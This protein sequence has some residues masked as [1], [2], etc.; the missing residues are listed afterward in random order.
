LNR[1]VIYGILIF[2]TLS[3]VFGGSSSSGGNAYAQSTTSTPKMFVLGSE[4]KSGA[5]EI[6][7]RAVQQGA[8]IR[9]IKTFDIT[10][11]NVVQAKQGGSIK[12]FSSDQSLKIVKAKVRTDTAIENLIELPRTQGNTF[13]LTGLV[14]G[15]Y[16]LDIIAQK[17]NRDL[18]YETILVILDP[19]ETTITANL[20]IINNIIT[21]VKTEVNKTEKNIIKIIRGN[22]GGNDGDGDPTPQPIFAPDDSC[23]LDPFQEK[24][25]PPEGQS[26]P[27]GFGSNE[28][29]HCIPDS[30]CPQGYH[31]VDDVE[32]GQCHPKSELTECTGGGHVLK[33]DDCVYGEPLDTLPICDGSTQRCRVALPTG[34]WHI[35]EI[36]TT[37][38]EC[39]IEDPEVEP[40]ALQP[41]SAVTTPA[42]PCLN[43]E[44]EQD[45]KQCTTGMDVGSIACSQGKTVDQVCAENPETNGCGNE[46][47]PEPITLEPEQCIPGTG[48]EDE[49]C[50]SEIPDTVQE[51]IPQPEPIPE[52]SAFGPDLDPEEPGIQQLD[53]EPG[54]TFTPA[55]PELIPDD[56][57]GDQ[58]QEII[59]DDSSDGD[60]D[61]NGN[62]DNGL[63]SEDGD[64]SNGGSAEEDS[65]SDNGGD[66]Q[67]STES[68]GEEEEGGGGGGESEGSADEEG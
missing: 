68:G 20:Q 34:N 9:Q 36:G 43:D 18:A 65:D 13:S 7:L 58:D 17:N 27:E 49:A 42:G 3:L 37:D 31:M 56:S 16:I 45:F 21:K 62:G 50:E 2:T 10:I 38:H 25:I 23:A 47:Q 33:G 1:T 67:G 57:A 55:E 59:G 32:T 39:E 52:D 41:C 22:G 60:G 8:Q 19:G 54:E 29:G 35:C 24:C 46:P 61:D 14:A 40:V 5:V 11:D 63:N 64:D 12:A 51:N 15:V 44:G 28:D 53:Q 26:C 66:D 4:D 48:T 30:G 6:D